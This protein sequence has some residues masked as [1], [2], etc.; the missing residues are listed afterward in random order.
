MKKVLA[1]LLAALMSL[2]ILAGCASDKPEE[3][4]TPEKPEEIVTLK[5]VAVGNGMPANYDAW[6]AHINEY[7]GEKIGVNVEM[8]IISWGDWDS[9]RNMI[10]STNEPYDIMFTDGNTYYNDVSMGAFAD[11]SDM[12]ETAA[13]NLYKYIPAAYWDTCRI[14]GGLYAVPTYKDSSQTNYFVYDQNLVEDIYPDYANMHDIESATKV[15]E[16]L[17]EKTNA[18]AMILRKTGMISLITNKYDDI[19][20]GLPVIGV[21]YDGDAAK[22]EVVVTLEQENLKKD[23]SILGEWYE[24]GYINSD[25]AI[26]DEDPK[27]KPMSV[28][29]GWPSAAKTTWGPN[30][31]V[32]AIAIQMEETVLSNATVQGS[33][34]CIS[35][36]C[37]HPEKAL[38]LLEMINLD[39]IVRDAF[40]YGLEGDNF[41]YI[42][43]DGERRVHKNNTDWSMAG[44]TQGTFFTVTTLEDDQYN[45]WNEVKT[46]NESAKASPVLGFSF[47]TAPISDQL[48]ACVSIWKEYCPTIMTGTNVS[49]IDTMLESMRASGLDEI[50]AEAQ[51]QIDAWVKSK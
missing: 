5:M 45:Q 38:Q 42:E 12:I 50:I 18:P 14:N 41:D 13:P 33:L 26:L 21:S 31:G 37:K 39:P 11:I 19:S 20:T 1:L 30:M 28:A 34:N 15:V 2:S 35:R 40:F 48:S 3:T 27:Y 51:A 16:A 36:A 22:P 44:Y 25:A 8:E 29:Q 24:K 32:E 46:L 10:V 7:L 9:R 43:K 47:D 23:L 49:Q 4:T 6:K 17:S